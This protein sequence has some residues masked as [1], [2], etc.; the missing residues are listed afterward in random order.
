MAYGSILGQMPPIPDMEAS[1]ISYDNATSQLTATNVQ[2]AI[3]EIVQ[4]TSGRISVNGTLKTGIAAED[5]TEGSFVVEGGHYNGNTVTIIER[6]SSSL[7]ASY[8]H[9]F[10]INS[11]ND[12]VVFAYAPNSSYDYYLLYRFVHFTTESTEITFLTDKNSYLYSNNANNASIRTVN[13]CKLNNE[14]YI[15]AYIGNSNTPYLLLITVDTT[16]F[17]C[18]FGTPYEVPLISRGVVGSYGC[19]ISIERLDDSRF[20]F[21][22]AAKNPEDNTSM[23]RNSLASIG[24]VNY[25]SGEIEIGNRVVCPGYWAG[26][27]RNLPILVFSS[28]TFVIIGC[29]G[30]SDNPLGY[31]VF[32]SSGGV[33]YT[34]STPNGADTG[35][36]TI[37]GTMRDFV[38]GFSYDASRGIVLN[39]SDNNNT[40]IN[41][42]SLVDNTL[43]VTDNITIDRISN[44]TNYFAQYGNYFYVGNNLYLLAFDTADDPALIRYAITT[45]TI[46]EVEY[47]LEGNLT[48][49]TFINFDSF[50]DNNYTRFWNIGT[51]Q[52][53]SKIDAFLWT[54]E[55]FISN[56]TD[57]ISG[58]S[59]ESA[60]QGE[61]I[62][63]YVP[64]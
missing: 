26:E 56:Y 5:I 21:C 31:K 34:T 53:G 44:Y 3:D 18:T 29:G 17:T 62:N 15:M 30:S 39:S 61:T 42:V 64:N 54:T 40:R 24:M 12:Y 2:A 46:S 22:F 38:S 7:A 13:I 60:S 51:A 28:N 6:L 57:T 27:M 33:D 19:S 52:Y 11:N 63:Y 47:T 45:S 14:Q 32:N 1:N 35:Y 58:I 9:T 25:E 16:N 49:P 59:S 37:F 36:T 43:T 10:P 50:S 41:L 8:I 4:N 48:P 55:T 23:A 20:A